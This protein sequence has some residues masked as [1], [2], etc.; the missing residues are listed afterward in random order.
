MNVETGNLNPQEII[1]KDKSAE[2]VWITEM[3]HKMMIFSY[4][5]FR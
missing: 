1:C 5:S 3:K 2:R 4:Y